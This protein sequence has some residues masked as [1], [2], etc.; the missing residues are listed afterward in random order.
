M[1]FL[2]L[3]SDQNCNRNGAFAKAKYVYIIELKYFFYPI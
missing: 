1:Y 3:S 2:S